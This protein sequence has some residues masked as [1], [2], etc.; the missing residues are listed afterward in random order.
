[1]TDGITLPQGI[2]FRETFPR[3]TLVE[4]FIVNVTFFRGLDG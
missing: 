1:M 4:N 3:M 2:G